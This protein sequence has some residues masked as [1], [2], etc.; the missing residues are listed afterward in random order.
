MDHSSRREEITVDESEE[1]GKGFQLGV[2][3]TYT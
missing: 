2:I 1:M 3:R